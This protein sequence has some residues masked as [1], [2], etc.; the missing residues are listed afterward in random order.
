MRTS[1]IS[2]VLF[3]FLF[4]ALS[5]PSG[6][7]APAGAPDLSSTMEAHKIVLDKENREIAVSAEKVFPRDKIEYTLHYRNVGQAPATGVSLVGPIPAGTVYIDKTA[8]N[9]AAVHPFYSIDGGKSYHR[10]PFT[11]LYVDA[12]GKER[13]RVATPDMYTHIKWNIDGSLDAGKDLVVSYRVQVK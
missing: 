6:W 8:S 2:A 3:A 1:L 7:A 11:Y 9:G 4:V 12:S 10:A 13:R 5:S